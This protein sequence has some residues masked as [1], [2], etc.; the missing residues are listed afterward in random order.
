MNEP[1]KIAMPKQ[2]ADSIE[3][4]R[5][6]I[7]SANR[8]RKMYQFMA[9]IIAT[10]FDLKCDYADD[11]RG[12]AYWVRDGRSSLGSMMSDYSYLIFKDRPTTYARNGST[13]AIDIQ[14]TNSSFLFSK[15]QS[16]VYLTQM[17]KYLLIK[18]SIIWT[19]R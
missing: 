10:A 5:H 17:E 15:A 14:S 13:G 11:K 6:E 16:I 19:Q 7:R 3:A 4:S 1:H 8:V 12:W 18:E 9:V 2:K